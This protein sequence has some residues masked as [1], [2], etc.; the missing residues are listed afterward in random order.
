MRQTSDAVLEFDNMPD[1]AH[2]RPKDCAKIIGVSIA[3]YWRQ[4]KKGRIKTCKLTDR[5]TSTRAGD[6]RD[7]MSGKGGT[8]ETQ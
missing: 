3:T 2:I 5:T 8:D 7:F 1:S 4:V 6:L